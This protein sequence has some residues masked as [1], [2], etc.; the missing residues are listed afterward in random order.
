MCWFDIGSDYEIVVNAGALSLLVLHGH[1]STWTL[2]CVSV[3]IKPTFS[4]APTRPFF[5]N[6]PP[7]SRLTS[8]RCRSGSSVSSNQPPRLDAELLFALRSPELSL[9]G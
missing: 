1:A 6:A 4:L 8:G 7:S 9:G 2:I 5:F 3:N